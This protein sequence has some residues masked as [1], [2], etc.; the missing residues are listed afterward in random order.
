VPYGTFQARAYRGDPFFGALAGVAAG[1]AGKV[2]PAAGRA[3]GIIKSRP[4]LGTIAGIAGGVGLPQ[5]AGFVQK[6]PGGIGPSLPIPLPGGIRVDPFAALPG[7]RPFVTRE[8]E[9]RCP[10]G[11]RPNKSAY[12][13]RDGSYVPA[14][15]RCVRSR[16]MNVANPKAL[17][18][19]IRR[20]RGFAKLSRTVIRFVSPKPA[21]GRAIGKTR[22]R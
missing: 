10:S 21:R 3:L 13:L 9:G 11:F 20:M 8:M 18:K 16:R 14:G 4:A 15:T 7:G 22:R 6:P 12:F 19:G 2:L 17:R 1:I 5:I